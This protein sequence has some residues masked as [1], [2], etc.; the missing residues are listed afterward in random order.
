MMLA[1]TFYIGANKYQEKSIK[2]GGKIIVDLVREKFSFKN[3]SN[4]SS[5]K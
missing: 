5:E 2:L 4:S 1:M 3:F